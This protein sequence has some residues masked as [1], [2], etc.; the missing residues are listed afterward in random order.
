M[1]TLGKIQAP[2][3]IEQKKRAKAGNPPEPNY[4]IPSFKNAKVWITSLP[5]GKP[6]KKPFLITSPEFQRWMEKAADSLESQLL[7]KCQTGSDGTPQ[8][9][10][11]LFAMCL[12]L[13][14]DDSVRDLPEGQ[15][16]VVHV[17]PGE[18]GAVIV[19]EEV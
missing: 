10:S 14:A 1:L 11:K 15:W 6:L 3:T 18:E 4:H 16:K 19:I 2:R 7:S 8:V 12:S 5:N 13:P 17:P 9:R